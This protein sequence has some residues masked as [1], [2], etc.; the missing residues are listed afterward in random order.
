MNT[1]DIALLHAFAIVAS[2]HCEA[3]YRTS[4]VSPETLQLDRIADYLRS[5]LSTFELRVMA[6]GMHSAHNWSNCESYKNGLN[7]NR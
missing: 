1:R 7:W 3:I 4:A 6:L 2:R 5:Q